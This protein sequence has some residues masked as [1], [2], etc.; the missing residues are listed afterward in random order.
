MAALAEDPSTV[1]YTNPILGGYSPD[2][3]IVKA[4]DGGFYLINSSFGS[5]PGIPVHYS[6]DLVH[7]ELV[8]YAASQANIQPG[9][10]AASLGWGM[11]GLY[12]PT[13]R[14]NNGTYYMVVTNFSNF[15]V[16]I[17][18]ST[19][20]KD[21]NGWS[22]PL[23]L[24]LPGYVNLDPDL[25]FDT[26]G[27]VWLTA[28]QMGT[29]TAVEL[30]LTT[31]RYIGSPVPLFGG[32]ASEAEG[33]HVYRIG[34]YYYLSL[35]EGGTATNHMQTISRLDASIGLANSTPADWEVAPI[36]INTPGAAVNNYALVRYA[37]DNNLL[38][39]GNPPFNPIINNGTTGEI[40]QTGHADLVADQNGNWWLVFLG[41]RPEVLP[42]L[43]RETFLAPVTWVD[44]WPVVNGGNPITT[45][46][47][48]PRVAPPHA[49]T[50]TPRD[51]FNSAVLDL[52]WNY[53]YNPLDDAVS[54]TANPGFLTLQTRGTLTPAG[55]T[56]SATS[57]RS[58]LVGQ[59]QRDKEMTFTTKLAFEPV[60][61]AER[62]G[63]VMYGNGPSPSRGPGSGTTEFTIQRDNGA[64]RLW[65]NLNGGGQT[66][67][68][69]T[70]P[71]GSA[72]E[73][74]LRVKCDNEQYEFIYSLNGEDW[75]TLAIAPSS[76]VVAF[77]GFAGIFVGLWATSGVANVDTN[78][79][80]LVD[81]A[82]YLP[83]ANTDLSG[84]T[85]AIAAAAALTGT[86]FTTESWQALQ[87]VIAAAQILADDG[88]PQTDVDSATAAVL[89]AIAG[90]T[91]N[92]P[93][94]YDDSAIRA[95]LDALATAVAAIP[96]A[97]YNDAAVRAALDAL[98][99]AVA[100]I[101]TQAYNDSAVQSALAALATAVAAIPTQ[102]GETYNDAAV[103]AALNALAAA[104]A[105]IPTDQPAQYDDAPIR[106]AIAD[107]A[108]QIGQLGTTQP[109]PA[110]ST[111]D[112]SAVR[113]SLVALTNSIAALSAQAQLPAAPPAPATIKAGSVKVTGTA[114]VGKKLTA[115]TASWTAGVKL[116]YKWYASGKVIKNAKAKTLKLTKAM[117]GKKI[118]VKVT[119][120]KTG[121]AAAAKT[122]KTTKKVK[123]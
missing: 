123:S 105:A 15:S 61:D 57:G 25:L 119:A 37:L 111:Y 3:S 18:T 29:I 115:K 116:T 28:S 72:T 46:M 8:S 45:T 67:P 112:D 69:I 24:T 64:N 44:D 9:N 63:I 32:I 88:G 74:W 102:P 101:P 110:Q 77:P 121:L 106:Q 100:A 21:P 99:T 55:N 60:N 27:K 122:S 52:R 47:T 7:W 109:G 51:N 5:A 70:A 103:R 108:E 80:A 16:F 92:Q 49:F 1:T 62:A 76:D 26:D 114:K 23:T 81:W 53:M 13:I 11:D 42:N 71:L 12:A 48:G 33:P 50:T 98:T 10:L 58:S 73:V 95:A 6:E 34:D 56:S 40:T 96:T 94:P 90:L 65:L 38:S 117:A 31:G 93:E 118:K 39:D 84:L 14:E 87:D 113:A 82:E 66:H 86:D 85:G 107:L 22:T 2:P 30:N 79:P 54:L 4:H 19:N 68:E 41:T 17:T 104:V 89:A 91:V 75:T 83:Y 59:R 36:R 20:P 35:A 43:A 120:T 97:S 78:T